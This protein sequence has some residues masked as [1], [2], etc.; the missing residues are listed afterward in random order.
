MSILAVEKQEDNLE[1][2]MKVFILVARN[3][4]QMSLLTSF[5]NA[6]GEGLVAR[7]IPLRLNKT[8]LMM[9]PWFSVR[10]IFDWMINIRPKNAFHCAHRSKAAEDCTPERIK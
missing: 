1:N 3:N 5:T 7:T 2:G 8:G 6:E 10:K 4:L 9:N